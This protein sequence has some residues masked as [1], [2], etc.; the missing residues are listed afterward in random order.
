MRKILTISILLIS[1]NFTS[2]AQTRTAANVDPIVKLI[3][4][5]PTPA[6]TGINFDFQRGF[7]KNLSLQL[8]NFMGKKVYETKTTTQ[9]FY[10]PL[11][12]FY[13]GVYVYQLR[14]KTGK[15]LQSGKFQVVK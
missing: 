5:Y 2:F 11:T 13:R 1:L 12:D 6:A 15:I 7:D 9:R 8:Y 3:K 14:D 4:V 10:L